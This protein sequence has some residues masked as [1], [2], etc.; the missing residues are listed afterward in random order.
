MDSGD[1]FTDGDLPDDDLPDEGTTE[2]Q[3]GWL[4][5]DDRLWRHPSELARLQP[6]QPSGSLLDAGAGGWHNRRLRRASV[7]ATV[8]GAA[9]LATTM[10]VVITIIDTQT[11]VPGVSTNG[12]ARTITVSTTSL[13]SARV[14]IG[15]DVVRLVSSIRPSLVDVDPVGST[16]TRMTGVVLPGGNLVVTAA[17][18]VTGLTSVTVVTADGKRHRGQV[19]GSDA[20]AG[21][22]VIDTTGGLTPATFADEVVQPDDLDVVACLCAEEPDTS[23]VNRDPAVASVGMVRTVSTGVILRTGPTLVNGIEADMSV[24]PASLG[25]A[26]LDGRGHVVGVLAGEANDRSDTV[27]VFVPAPLV[28]GVASQLAQNHRVEHGWLGVRCA[29]TVEG[30]A[31]VNEVLPGSPAAAAGLKPGDRVVAVDSHT[32]SSLADLQERLYIVPPGAT[33][34]LSVI[35]ANTPTAMSIKLANSPGG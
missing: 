7:A 5:P 2:P 22:A 12:V 24:G 20:T 21:V 4:P 11:A 8:V 1:A 35:R 30:G 16:A 17:S 33:V 26:L 9:A 25:G 6:T 18:A 13:T 31:T 3:R 28:E 29:S 34:Q 23:A 27:G 32:V 10:A 15:P 19:V 14:G